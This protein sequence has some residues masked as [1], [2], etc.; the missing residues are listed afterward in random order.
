MGLKKGL[1][2]EDRRARKRSFLFYN[3][4]PNPYPSQNSAL[5]APQNDKDWKR[6]VKREKKNKGETKDNFSLAIE[7]G[8]EEREHP[9]NC[10]SSVPVISRQKREDNKTH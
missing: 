9:P 4:L 10:V 7:K 3:D 1:F 2:K 5:T 6:R 8:K